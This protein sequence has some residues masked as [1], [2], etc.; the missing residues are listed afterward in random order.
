VTASKWTSGPLRAD[1]RL[2]GEQV[3]DGA[4]VLDLGCGSGSLLA[5]LMA[6]RGCS[7]TGVEIDPEKVL[8]AIR[9]GVPVIELDV[10]HQLGEFSDESYDVCV[11]SRTIQ[12][13]Q[14]PEHVLRE[15]ARIAQTLVVSVPNFGW[16]GHRLRLLRGRMPMSKEL[17]YKWYDTPNIRHTTLI[18][19]EK[20]F[21]ALEL[22]IV[23]RFTFTE[24]GRRLHMQGARANLTA[25]AAVYVLRPE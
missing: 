1:L 3:P 14:R 8:R 17:P 19:L 23:N 13:I 12:T 25:G 7:G 16:W 22:R 21:E 24:T 5:W 4:R 2:V 10:D 11:L 15:M 20:L 6:E 9:R 18:D